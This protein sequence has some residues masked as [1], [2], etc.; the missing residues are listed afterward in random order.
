M[1]D[2]IE[3]TEGYDRVEEDRHEEGVAFYGWGC[4]IEGGEIDVL[5]WEGR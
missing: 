1:V 4:G 3:E 5:L 2:A